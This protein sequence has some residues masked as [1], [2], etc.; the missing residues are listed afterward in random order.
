[1]NWFEDFFPHLIQYRETF[2]ELW[3]FMTAAMLGM[4]LALIISPRSSV[5]TRILAAIVAVGVTE[6]IPDTPLGFMS[7]R[8]AGVQ[9]DVFLI[10][11]ALLVGI[12]GVFRFLTKKRIG[13]LAN[14]IALVVTSSLAIG[15]HMLLINGL[16]ETYRARDAYRLEA[17][18]DTDSIDCLQVATW[19]GTGIPNTGHSFL[20]KEIKDWV[21][22]AV[23]QGYQGKISDSVGTLSAMPTFVWAA[24]IQN[25]EIT[26]I[27]QDYSHKTV[28]LET[29]FFL[30]IFAGS[31]FWFSGALL[32]EY[33]HWSML[34]RRRK[35]AA[36]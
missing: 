15:Y 3:H 21:G 32:L 9:E 19:C 33:L 34:R 14:S 10:I 18:L 4:G 17:F 30:I 11:I 29:V 20:N 2:A 6:T 35:R 16:D 36:R 24:R 1:M 28:M 8:L 7:G 27:A 5:V 13:L 12:T 23:S 31:A 22:A 26:W 25:D